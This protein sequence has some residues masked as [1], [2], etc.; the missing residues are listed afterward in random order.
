VPE[1]RMRAV[2]PATVSMVVECNQNCVQ[3]TIQIFEHVC[4]EASNYSITLCVQKC[5]PIFIVFNFMLI[6]MRRS[7][8]FQNKF[9][10]MAKEVND[11]WPDGDLSVEFVSLKGFVAQ[12]AP[13]TLLRLRLIVPK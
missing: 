4:V 13:K 5:S 9:C 8:N 2:A 12:I 1:G 7:I 11:V 10:F 3:Y 6:A